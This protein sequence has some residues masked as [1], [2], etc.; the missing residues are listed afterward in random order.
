MERNRFNEEIADRLGGTIGGILRRAV[1]QMPS[2]PANITEI[3]IRA[4][5]PLSLHFIK[6]TS[7]LTHN[8]TSALEKQ[9]Y[10]VTMQDI[11][12]TIQHVCQ[13]SRYAYSQDIR[14][15]FITVP[16]GHRIGLA[17]RMIH[18]G[19]L[20]E[21]SSMTVRVAREI[22]EAGK[23]VFP[24]ILRDNQDI[25]STLIISPPGCGK[26]TLLRDLARKMSNG[27][28]NHFFTGLNV[29]I[30]DE[31][32]EIAA[33]YRGVPSNDLG[34]RTDVYDGCPKDKGILMMLRSMAPN[35][36]VTDELGGEKDMDAVLSAMNGGVR[37]LATAHGY[38]IK[39][40]ALRPDIARI[41]NA[42]LFERYIVLSRREG[43]GTLEGVYGFYKEKIYERSVDL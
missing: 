16:G 19:S 11:H 30:V 29:G 27:D 32:S 41:V 35:V 22:K 39:D 15:G 10:R 23:K 31:R 28:T 18:D 20:T 2:L 34:I 13:H 26:T 6:G 25:Y 7:F 37:I 36:I 3:R 14:N 12:E 38:G 1:P 8:G 43:A 17:G 21:I 24:Y 33:C 9:A 42:C 4:G 5:Q 40:N